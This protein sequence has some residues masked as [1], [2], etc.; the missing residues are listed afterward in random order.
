M[1]TGEKLQQQDISSEMFISIDSHDQ[2]IESREEK[3]SEGAP[4][5]AEDFV[6]HNTRPLRNRRDPDRYGE[7]ASI[8]NAVQP[9]PKTYKQALKDKNAAETILS[10]RKSMWGIVIGA[11]ELKFWSEGAN[12][13]APKLVQ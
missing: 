1:S 10:R 2:Q 9:E 8:A 13:S 11:I 7:W 5:N 4:E 12:N 3:E 6:H